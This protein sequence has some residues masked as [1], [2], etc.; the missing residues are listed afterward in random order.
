MKLLRAEPGEGI[1]W[2]R[3]ACQVFLR[4]P[5]GLAGLFSLCALV[6]FAVSWIP[7]V[8]G[9]LLP[10]LRARRLARLHDRHPPRP[11]RRTAAARRARDAA[12]AP[13]GRA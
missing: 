2:I 5:F 10:V 3:R 9:A 11:G 7:V 8:G 4:Q 6:A 12:R 13:A 1:V